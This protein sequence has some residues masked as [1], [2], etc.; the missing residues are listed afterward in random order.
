MAGSA[1]LLHQEDGKPLWVMEVP[2]SQE[3]I[4]AALP[5]MNPFCHGAVCFRREEAVKVGGYRE[6]FV[7]TQDYDF[8]WRIA[9]RYGACNLTDPLYHHRCTAGSISSKRAQEQTKVSYMTRRLAQM[10][11]QGKEDFPTALAEA[12]ADL[13]GKDSVGY[14]ELRQADRVMMAGHYG[15][16][17]RVYR[18]H[19]FR[20]PTNL[21][22]WSKLVRLGL[23]VAL[24]PLRKRL[25]HA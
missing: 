22:A 5:T 24:P 21:R 8:F 2:S 15:Q 7:C 20:Q 10:R 14:D 16:A 25:F 13:R 23:F 6:E 19:A 18:K 4:L 17:F 12:E 1:V 11:A 3:A 9:E